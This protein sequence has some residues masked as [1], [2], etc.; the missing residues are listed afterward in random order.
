MLRGGLFPPSS[1]FSF[2]EAKPA[3]SVSFVLPL[4]GTDKNECENSETSAIPTPLEGLSRASRLIAQLCPEA[5]PASLAPSIRS[6]QFEG[7]FS[8]LA[9]PPKEPFTP[10]LF[11]H[12]KELLSQ[13]CERFVSGVNSRK[14]PL[15]SLLF[16]KHPLAASSDPEFGRA[17]VPNPSLSCIIGSLLTLHSVGVRFAEL[18]RLESVARQ[19]LQAQSVSFWIFNPFDCHPYR[20]REFVSAPGRNFRCEIFF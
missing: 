13:S 17:A 1:S 4:L 20:L 19:A 6:C 12:V 9:T 16:K 2:G 11:H 7:L 5:I 8:D 18:A 14:A 10:V 3:S 15:A